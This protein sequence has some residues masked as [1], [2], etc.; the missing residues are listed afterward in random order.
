M[1]LTRLRYEVG[2]STLKDVLVRQKEL[3][4]AKSKK[5]NAIYNYNLNL[6]ELER[7]TFLKLNNDCFPNEKDSICNMSI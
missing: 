2:I 1:R 7:L 3:S 6:D 4:N 5:I